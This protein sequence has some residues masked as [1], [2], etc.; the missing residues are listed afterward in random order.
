M[1]VFLSIET[2]RFEIEF[3]KNPQLGICEKTDF[4]TE[5]ISPKVDWFFKFERQEAL[6]RDKFVN[7]VYVFKLNQIHFINLYEF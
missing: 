6:V 1:Q 7:L 2:K 5:I 4:I 3:F